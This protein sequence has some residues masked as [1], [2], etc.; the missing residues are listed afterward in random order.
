VR[1]AVI[2]AF[3]RSINTVW[4]VMT[5]LCV[6]CLVLGASRIS[7][8]SLNTGADPSNL[9]VTAV[10]FIRNYS[11]KR[12]IVKEG[13]KNS[14][15]EASSGTVT[16]V[17]QVASSGPP[18]TPQTIEEKRRSSVSDLEKGLNGS[19]DG[20]ADVKDEEDETREEYVK[21]G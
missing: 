7:V 8:V 12:T 9:C 15:S 21:K 1:Q 2:H 20:N 13:R 16:P 18:D 19:E 10:L 3:T 11:M 4:I 17:T 14:E 5:P 6:V